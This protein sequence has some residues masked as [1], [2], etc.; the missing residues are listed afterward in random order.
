MKA[1]LAAAG[2]RRD[3]AQSQPA[4]AAG[5]SGE[6]VSARVAQARSRARERGDTARQAL[7][8]LGLVLLAV[9]VIASIQA[10]PAPDC[11]A[12]AWR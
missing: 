10:S 8:P 7:R 11:G 5:G 4:P 1:R 3:A 6:P 12:L 2:L 9:V